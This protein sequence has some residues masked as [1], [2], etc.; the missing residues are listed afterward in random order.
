MLEKGGNRKD[1]SRKK[2]VCKVTRR[3]AKTAYDNPSD[4]GQRGSNGGKAQRQT[5]QSP[6]RIT[7]GECNATSSIRDT[8]AEA[9]K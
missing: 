6:T 1:T 5:D 2:K 7:T 8:G 3:L 4:Q 9:L